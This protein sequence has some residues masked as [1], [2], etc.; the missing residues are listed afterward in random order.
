KLAPLVN[1]DGILNKEFGNMINNGTDINTMLR[2][3]EEQI[4]QAILDAKSK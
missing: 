3:A 1:A 2:L 4:N